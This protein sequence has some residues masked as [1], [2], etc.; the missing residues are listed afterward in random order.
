MGKMILELIETILFII[1]AV[2]VNLGP[3]SKVHRPHPLFKYFFIILFIR[4]GH[5]NPEQSYTLIAH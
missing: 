2:I 5:N 1:S 4:L 3:D